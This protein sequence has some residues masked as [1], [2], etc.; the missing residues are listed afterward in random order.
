MIR[1][2]ALFCYSCWLIPTCTT[3][4]ATVA[5]GPDDWLAIADV[6]VVVAAAAKPAVAIAVV[7][8]SPY[9]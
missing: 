3:C 2:L 8:I 7:E 1:I 6:V 4:L 5:A 9:C